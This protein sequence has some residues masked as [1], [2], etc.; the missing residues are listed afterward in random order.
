LSELLSKI[1]E[2]ADSIQSMKGDFN[3]RIGELERR[4][5]RARDHVPAKTGPSLGEM[6][7]ASDG[8][9][10]LTSSFRGKTTLKF[11]NVE[12]ATITS[13]T[14][15]TGATTSSGTSLVP[16]ARVPGI[17][18]PL[19]QQFSIRSLLPQTPTISSAVEVGVETGFTNAFRP[20]TETTTKPTSDIQFNLKS[21]PVRT[22]ASIF[23]ASRQIMDDAPMLASYIN[24]RGT[25]GLKLVEEGQLLT[26]NGTNQNLSGLIPQAS[27]YDDSRNSTG[28]DELRVLLHAISQ[29]SE[30]SAPV[31]GIVLSVKDWYNI[32][33]IRDNMGRYLSAGPFST[34]PPRIWGLPAIPSLSMNDGDFLVGSFGSGVGA[35]IFDRMGIEVL[36][37]TED[38]DNFS[39][40]QVTIR[41]ENRLTLATYRP[42]AFVSGSFS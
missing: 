17:I 23:K 2:V 1:G 4:A 11:P 24:K 31:T 5:A 15:S 30:A 6:V 28:D 12:S 22:L 33:G 19:V 26:G 25:Y 9:K 13:G 18:D 29:A 10:E 36:L 39:T 8:F 20:V 7:I 3:T 40:N 34:T 35:E 37:S 16:A 27:V 21:F 14:D 38:G 32:L 42:E 41:V